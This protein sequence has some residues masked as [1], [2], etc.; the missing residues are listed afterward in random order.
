MKNNRRPV[1]ACCRDRYYILFDLNY[2][3]FERL[4]EQKE[5]LCGKPCDHVWM[6]PVSS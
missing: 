3:A 2:A 5:R 4:R 1:A 6:N